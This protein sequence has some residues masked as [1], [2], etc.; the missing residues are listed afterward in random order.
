VGK[1]TDEQYERLNDE[2]LRPQINAA[3]GKLRAGFDFQTWWR[4]RP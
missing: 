1:I 2:R 3:R 4:W